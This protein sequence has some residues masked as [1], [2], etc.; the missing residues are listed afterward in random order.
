MLQAMIPM[1]IMPFYDTSAPYKSFIRS[2][3][4]QALNERERD[5]IRKLMVHHM[6]GP[7]G[8][9]AITV[10]QELTDHVKE[11]GARWGAYSWRQP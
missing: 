4:Y 7:G 10:D 9:Q 5:E 3:P 6:A 8:L 11:T 1:Y 2:D